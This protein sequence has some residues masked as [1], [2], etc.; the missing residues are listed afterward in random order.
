MAIKKYPIGTKIK[1]VGH[2]KKCKGKVGK[3]V[4][5][6]DYGCNI[7]LPQSLC[8]AAG[9]DKRLICSWSDIEPVSVKNEQLLFAFME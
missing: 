7:T 8:R 9:Q 2:C 1:Y 6:W 4:D 3:V 5:I